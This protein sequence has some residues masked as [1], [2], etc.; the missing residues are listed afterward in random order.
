MN[1]SHHSS[2]LVRGVCLGRAVRV[3]G[4]LAAAAAVAV[5]AAEPPKPAAGAAGTSGK[6]KMQVDLQR[7]TL[8]VV[9]GADGGTKAGSASKPQAAPSAKPSL[10]ADGAAGAEPQAV[11]KPEPLPA[12]AG[13]VDADTGAEPQAAPS[14]KPLQGGTAAPAPVVDAG[15]KPK[16]AAA[17]AGPAAPAPAVDALPADPLAEDVEIRLNFR[18]APLDAVL[19]H[20]SKAAGF[21]IVREI[22]VSGTLDVWSHQPVN[23]DE[24]VQLLNTILNDKGYAAIR[25]GRVIKI[26][27]RDDAKTRDIPVHM[28][29]DPETIPRH[30]VMVTQIIPITHTD[31]TRLVDNIKPLLP[32]HAV[33]TANESSNALVLTDT[34]TSIRRIAQI[35]TALDTSISDIL[36]VKVISLEH[37]TA[38]DVAD[39]INEV[40][41][42]SSGGSSGRSGDDRADRM[43]EFMM[44]MRGGGPPGGFGGGRGPG[45]GRGR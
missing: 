40:Y 41:S 13:A 31:A 26:I 12:T 9:L 1:H 29:A 34:Q 23:R 14:A 6:L 44:R 25:N 24:A 15:A 10:A 30:D 27:N 39:V 3:V 21:I 45:G 11:A 18:Q 42:A 20:L 5:S 4:W 32:E 36:D 35:V 17:E 7:T 37:A 8:G 38:A 33:L 2:H 28:G 43:R 19:D 16:A 22:E